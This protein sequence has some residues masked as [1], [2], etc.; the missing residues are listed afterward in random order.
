MRLQIANKNGGYMWFGHDLRLLLLDGKATFF[1][2][3][4]VHANDIRDGV[5]F[6]PDGTF[7]VNM[8]FHPELKKSFI[9]AQKHAIP[10]YTVYIDSTGGPGIYELDQYMAPIKGT[11]NKLFES[12]TTFIQTSFEYEVE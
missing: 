7:W 3:C 12:S 9:Y 5:I 4:K 6:L 10:C 11:R 1:S 2:N 8:E